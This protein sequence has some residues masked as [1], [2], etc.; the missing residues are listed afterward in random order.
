M[1]RCSRRLSK[2]T[3][4]LRRPDVQDVGADVHRVVQRDRLLQAVRQREQ[5]DQPV[6]H[7]L[8]D[9]VERLGRPRATLSWASITPFGLPVVPAGEHE[10]VDLVRSSGAPT[11]RP[12]PPNRRGKVSSG[13][14]DRASTDRGGEALEPHLAR[15]RRVAARA[16]EQPRRRPT[17]PTMLRIASGAHPRSRAGRRSAA[18]TSRR[19]TPRAARASRATR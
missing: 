16:Q 1:T 9:P 3:R 12:A 11:P 13:S 8:D 14:S 2:M 15:V 6:L 10:L 19:S 7:R 17:P 5:R 18:R 4:G